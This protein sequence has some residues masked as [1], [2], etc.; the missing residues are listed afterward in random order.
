MVGAPNNLKDLLAQTAQGDRGAFSTLYEATSAKLY[1][2]V[3]RILRRRDVAEDVLQDVYVKIWERAS[4]Y[5]PNRASPMTWMAVIARN[6]ALDDV[7]RR[8]IASIEDTPEAFNVHAAV[9]DP[10]EAM[11]FR[12]EFAGLINCLQT[13][14]PERR[15]MIFLAY[16]HGMTREALAKRFAKPV[17]TIK[18]WLHRGLAQVRRCLG[19]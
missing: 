15:E 14:E 17:A 11:Q 4:E 8:T 13:I 7:R 19:L 10:L 9:D 2:I 18:T 12:E 16:Y 6:R 5:D 1:G 3:I